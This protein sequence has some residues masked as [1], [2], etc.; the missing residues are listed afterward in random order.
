MLLAAL[1][2]QE[3]IQR[4]GGWRLPHAPA[5]CPA[6]VVELIQETQAAQPHQRPTAP[7]VLRRLRHAAGM[8]VEDGGAGSGAADA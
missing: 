2:T 6:E 4:R 5:E 3:P 1:L 8:A 7:E